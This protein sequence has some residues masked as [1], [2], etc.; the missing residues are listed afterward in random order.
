MTAADLFGLPLSLAADEP[1]VLARVDAAFAGEATFVTFV[2][3]HAW[4]LK[5]RNADYAG[6]L[7]GMDLVLADGIAVAKAAGWTTG[8]SVPRLSFDATSLYLPV[9]GRLEAKGGGLFV[10][11]AKPGV[12]EGAVA[13]MRRTFPL[14]DYKGVLDGYQ[15]PEAVIEAILAARPQ[16]VL[17]GMGAPHQERFLARLREAGFSG[18]AF[19]CG[20]F[21]DQLALTERY[22]P[23]WVDRL[24]ARWLYRLLRE[25]GRL[26]RRYLVE[27][28]PFLAK[29]LRARLRGATAPLTR[30]LALPGRRGA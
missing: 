8:A 9:L 16:M 21:L 29:A 3:P 4:T 26:W 6:L 20:G 10:V 5:D 12:A 14:I 25:P 15:P 1:A 7:A 22:Y 18:I 28:R 11:G 24:E 13:R 17:C 19:T 2:N 23:A 27:Y 30:P